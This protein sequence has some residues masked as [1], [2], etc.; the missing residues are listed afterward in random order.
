MQSCPLPVLLSKDLLV[1][2]L[3]NDSTTIASALRLNGLIRTLFVNHQDP[4]YDTVG[5][6][7][8]SVIE[9]NLSIIC[10]CL[11]TMR[12][13]LRLV[14]RGSPYPTSAGASRGANRSSAHSMSDVRAKSRVAAG[15]NWPLPKRMSRIA[16]PARLSFHSPHFGDGHLSP[17]LSSPHDR[18]NNAPWDGT[19]GR[20]LV[21]NPNSFTTNRYQHVATARGDMEKAGE[22]IEMRDRNPHNGDE[23]GVA[24]GTTHDE[25]SQYGGS[26]GTTEIDTVMHLG[27]TR[28]VDGF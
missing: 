11:P 24:I 27:E 12:P 8:W 9:T 14:F 4:V 3:I 21:R 6:G 17:K 10:A 18:T 26:E 19:V 15:S 20:P 25:V 2:K 23:V 28:P 16:S 7:V 5:S 1:V 13:L 22:E